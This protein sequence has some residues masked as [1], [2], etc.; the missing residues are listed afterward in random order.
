MGWSRFR[1]KKDMPEGLW[2]KCPECGATLYKKDLAESL[3]VCGDC[4]HHLRLNARDRIASLADPGSF[5]EMWADLV[6]VDR[7]SFVDKEPYP[8]KVKKAVKSSGSNEAAVAGVMTIEGLPVSVCILDF[9]FMGGSM[10]A[11]V[12]EKVTRAIEFATAEKIP[13]MVLSCS[14]GARMHEGVLSLMQMG[15]SSAA[16]AR[17]DAAGGLFISVL[18][19]PTTGGVMASFAALGDVILAEPK[20][21]IGFAGPRVIKETLRTEL[22]EG[23]QTSEFLLEKGFIDR[24]VE[25]KELR[26]V[27]TQLMGFLW[28][29]DDEQLE[30]FAP[31]D[32]PAESEEKA[33]E[34]DAEGPAAS[35][36]DEAVASQA[37][38]SEEPEQGS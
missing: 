7:L 1:K 12:G 4:G 21:L 27:L 25:R 24:I 9:S 22:P 26:G 19:H 28:S 23:F 38:A 11:V 15:K 30:K 13:V 31:Q 17:H 5:R 20:A 14:G 3:S 33:P 6:P 32:V 29:Y 8:E 10:G 2:V 16:L 18:A 34:D 37:A 36:E 35:S